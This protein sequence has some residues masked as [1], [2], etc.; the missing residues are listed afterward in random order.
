MF[1][2]EY[3]R[4]SEKHSAGLF[5]NG[6]SYYIGIN[7]QTLLFVVWSFQFHLHR[8]VLR[9]KEGS[10]VFVQ[11]ENYLYLS[12]VVDKNIRRHNRGEIITNTEIHKGRFYIKTELRIKLE[13][14]KMEGRNTEMRE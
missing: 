11:N 9:G 7:C 3:H 6:G 5:V 2:S 13:M 8:S 14:G 10:Q 4:L 1:E 12:C